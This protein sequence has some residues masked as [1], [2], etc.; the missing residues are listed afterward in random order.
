[1][2]CSDLE[3]SFTRK[4]KKRKQGRV[5]H[6]NTDNG[7]LVSKL[8]PRVPNKVHHQSTIVDGPLRYVRWAA[9]FTAARRP[10]RV[11]QSIR[12]FK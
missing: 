11:E 4:L 2:A 5:T 12:G 9:C 7:G 3:T 10:L 6:F 1:M 8:W